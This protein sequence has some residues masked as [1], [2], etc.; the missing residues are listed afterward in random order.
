MKRPQPLSDEARV[1]RRPLPPDVLA[2]PYEVAQPAPT[3][4]VLRT[5]PVGVT[6]RP[7][8]TA[9]MTGELDALP[10]DVRDIDPV[11]DAVAGL[12]FVALA[13]GFFLALILAALRT[14]LSSAGV[15]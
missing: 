14:A 8:P 15:L 11:A 5:V 10:A 1:A 2:D 7:S 4:R 12:C 3:G 9:E 6:S 13:G